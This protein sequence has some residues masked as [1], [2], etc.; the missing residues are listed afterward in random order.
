MTNLKQRVKRR[1]RKREL[2]GSRF[3]FYKDI[4]LNMVTDVGNR[5]FTQN[6]VEQSRRH[7][8][9][10]YIYLEHCRII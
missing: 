8:R 9:E 2:K 5:T 10:S 1:A 7:F 4:K 6:I 3:S